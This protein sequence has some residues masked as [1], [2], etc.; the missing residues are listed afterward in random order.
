MGDKREVVL[1]AVR[2]S[3]GEGPVI[4]LTA[5][6]EQELEVAASMYM[7]GRAVQPNAENTL[8]SSASR[9]AT[10]NSLFFNQYFYR[11]GHIVIN[12]T[13]I[14]GSPSVVPVLQSP[15]K[16]TFN[17]YDLLRGNAITATG[18]T[19][20]K[21]Y[22][23]ITPIPNL[24]ANDILP[25]TYRLRMEHGNANAITYTAYIALIK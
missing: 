6:A 9:T 24:S 5:N 2:S 13:S 17:Y 23:G 15:E 8:F 21:L 14:T 19:V 7:D 25:L 4:N 22:P 1:Y 11:G 3:S 12:V 18:I 16:F 10:T 20:L